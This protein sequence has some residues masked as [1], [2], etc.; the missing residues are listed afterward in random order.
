[1]GHARF[2]QKFIKEF[3][4]IAKPRSDQLNRDKYF[5]FINACFITFEYLKE[6]LII[7][8]I[9]IAPD[10]KIDLELICYAS[11][12]VVYYASKVLNEAQNN[13]AATKKS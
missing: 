2:Y 6:K 13:Y 9:I 3:S 1:M 12:Y 4:K 11:D 5:D 8:P 10:W 7:T